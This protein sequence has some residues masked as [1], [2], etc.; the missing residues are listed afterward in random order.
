VALSEQEQRMLE[1]I[2]QALIADDPAFAERNRTAALGG[3][4]VGIR[5]IAVFLVGL[6]VL[7]GGIALAQSSLWFVILGLVGFFIMFA[8]GLM[9]F[10]SDRTSA[11]KGSKKNYGGKPKA[12]GN[13]GG[14]ADRMEDSFR[15]RFD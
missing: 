8:G 5:S 10:R 13:S 14:I 4:T 6:C 12:S 1:E 9:A 3:V 2:E 11:K 7:I 15:R